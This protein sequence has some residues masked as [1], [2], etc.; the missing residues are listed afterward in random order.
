M[1]NKYQTIVKEI[2]NK[3]IT[4]QWQRGER[5]AT[6]TELIKYFGTTAATLQK[7]M[8][9]LLA[10]GFIISNG[11]SGTFIADNPPN[12][13]RYGII[14]PQ[15]DYTGRHESLFTGVMQVYQVLERQMGI[16][17]QL[18]FLDEDNMHT[19][20]YCQLESDLSSE[21]VAGLI[22]I[23][24][25]VEYMLELVAKYN[26][27]SV[28]L[29]LD[30]LPINTVMVDY[31]EFFRQAFDRLLA[32]GC[33]NIAVL[34]NLRMPSCYIENLEQH[35][36]NRNYPINPTQIQA[37]SLE[38]ELEFW[39]KRLISLL[40]DKKNSAPVDG[41]II[42]NENLRD[43]A[44][45]VIQSLGLRIGVDIK[46]ISHA[47]FPV[48][49]RPIFPVEQFGFRII[50]ILEVCV[51]EIRNSRETNTIKYNRLIPPRTE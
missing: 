22:F 12:L 16:N 23:R 37:V 29:T 21:R 5:I 25:P 40:M 47:N 41:L 39:G 13:C 8:D 36:I 32:S 44:V 30:K 42:G 17:F 35:A 6:R 26:I 11:K 48:T 49:S 31:D 19:K 27:T 51:E 18:Y 50:E 45:S 2:K 38:Y 9:E 24:P 34:T 43:L 10:D 14:I 3:I 33:K 28:A 46:L 1:D 7:A 15:I 4:S 20:D